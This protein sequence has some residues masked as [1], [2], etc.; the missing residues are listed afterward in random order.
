ML[1][2]S[3]GKDEH[4]V[5]KRPAH[6]AVYEKLRQQILFGDLAPGQAV[7]IQGVTESLGAGM[8]PVREAIRRLISAGALTMMGNRRI[9]VPILT[10]NCVEELVFIREKLE[11]ALAGRAVSKISSKTLRRLKDE[12]DA[13]NMAIERGDISAYLTHNYRF[14]ARV[15]SIAE[16]PIVAATVDRLWLRFGPSLRVVCGRYGTMNLPDKHADLLEALAEGDRPAAEQA[17]KDDVQ[18]GMGQIRAALNEQNP[19]D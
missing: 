5:A 10:E 15:Y 9:T 7:T 16:A 19:A 18:Q 13:L 2:Y 1:N 4:T 14:H 6:E 8:T 11:P 17:M 12:D 3:A